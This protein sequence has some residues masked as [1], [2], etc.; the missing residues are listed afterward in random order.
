MLRH[1]QTVQLASE[2]NLHDPTSLPAS[3]KALAVSLSSA[4]GENPFSLVRNSLDEEPVD[5]R[6]DCGQP[7]HYRWREHL[8]EVDNRRAASPF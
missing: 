7:A 5:G 8:S 2:C 1:S 4:C 6:L 3:R